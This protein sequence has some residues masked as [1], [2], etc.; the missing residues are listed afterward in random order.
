MVG[1]PR[2]TRLIL[3]RHGE[4]QTA[5]D[6]RVGGPKGC[7]GLSALGRRQATA[8]RDRLATTGELRAADVLMA[9]TL[10]RAIETA[11]LIAPAVGDGRLELVTDEELV[12]LRPGEADELLW[13]E[14]RER[15]Q[16]EGWTWDPYVPLA[17]GAESWAGFMVRAG[18]ALSS[19]AR[20]HAGRTVVIACHGGI[21]EASLVAFGQLPAANRFEVQVDNTGLTEWV[22]RPDRR[23]T[24]SWALVRF[25]DSTHL[26]PPFSST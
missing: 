4:A 2:P 6:Q 14:Y 9:S 16:G 19:V 21:I 15:Y 17:P 12:E 22:Y 1:D 3:V 11:E 18:T 7:T 23:G 26:L 10:P 8:L 13:S 20:Q 25:N 5:V 24:E